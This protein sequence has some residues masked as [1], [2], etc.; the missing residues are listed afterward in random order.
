MKNLLLLKK[1]KTFA[2]WCVALLLLM[3]SLVSY[4]QAT[5]PVFRTAWGSE[6]T[7]W[8]NSGCTQRTSAFACTGSD[9][10]TFDTN[11][12]SRVLFFSGTAAQVVFQLKKSS[13][14]G[15][16][17]LTVTQS[18]DGVTYS[19]AIG[20][21]GTATGA[22][23]ITDCGNIT[24]PLLSTTRYIKWVYTK[25]TGNCDMDEVSVTAPASVITGGTTATTAFSTT[26]GTASA[27]K[28]FAVSGTL[29][30]NPL[31]AT[32]QTGFEV[33]RSDV[34][35]YGATASYTAA[36]ANAGGISFLVR[37]KNN[38]T[39]GNYNTQN[40][41][42]LSS[43]PATNANIV[44]SSS[45]N[46]VSPLGLTI[47]GLTAQDK[48][49]D[50]NNTATLTGTAV[51]N[52][53]LFS[54]DVVLGGTPS[55]TFSSAAVG[56]W[57]VTVTG[58]TISGTKAGN[59]TVSQPTVANATI[60]PSQLAD[61]VITFPA[62]GSVPYGTVSVNL[63]ATSDNPGG[64]PITYV[65]SNTA[66]ATISGNTAVIVGAGT[67]TITASQAGD[68]TH[69]PAIDQSQS[70][71]VT[72]LPITITGISA[73]DKP[74][75]GTTTA[76]LT[77]TAVL[78]PAPINSDVVNISGTP[79]AQFASANAGTQAVTVTGYTISGAQAGNYSFTQ[80]IVADATITQ[81]SQTITTFGTIPALTTLSSPITLNG[82]ASS[83]LT[84]TFESSNTSVATI[85]GTTMTIVGPG[86]VTITAKQVGNTNYSAAPELTQT[87]TVESALYLNQF[88]GTSA[89]PTQG[90]TP[91]VAAN[92]TG[93]IASRSTL[94]CASLNNFFSST[95]LNVTS[96][97]NNNSYIEF[98]ATAASGYLM[99]LTKMSFLRSGS[100]T[101]PNQL[102]VRY[103]TDGF[104]TSTSMNN[105][106]LTT[107]TATQLT[108]DFVD[109]STPIS[110][111]V[112]FRIYPYGTQRADL[113]TGAA[114]ATGTFRVDDLTIYG[115]VVIP[116]PTVVTVIP[117][118]T[119]AV[120]SAT[121]SGNVTATGG[122]NVLGNGIVYSSTDFTPTLGEPGVIQLANPAPSTGTGSYSVGT[123]TVLFANTEYYYNAYANSAQGYGYGTPSSFYTLANVP[124]QPN[125]ASNITTT[126]FDFDFDASNNPSS[127]MYAIQIN[128]QYLQ[129]N[130]TL[131]ATA[132]WQTAFN[133]MQ[134]PT[135]HLI[136][137]SGLNANTL[138]TY[139]VKARNGANVETAFG[140]SNSATTLPITTPTLEADPLSA[141]GNVCTNTSV[142]HTFA[143]LGT[144]LTN[145]VTIGPL[146]GFTFSITG[147][148]DYANDLTLTPDVNGDVLETIYVKF[149][150]TL[151]QS[152]S[153]TP[154]AIASV[155][156]TT[157]YVTVSG[158]GIN[159][160]ASATTGTASSI[161]S[162]GAS[163]S[164]SYTLGCSALTEFG[165]QYSTDSGFSSIVFVHGLPATLTGLN[166]NT[167][168][169]FRTYVSDASGDIVSAPA[170]QFTTANLDAPLA[171]A[172]TSVTNNSFVA[173]WNAVT[174]A[175]SY[176]LDVSSDPNFLGA[177]TTM[178]NWT[179]PNNPDNN[180]VDA[181]TTVNNAKTL[182]TQ[183]GVGTVGYTP[184]QSSA[185]SAA[186]A[187][188][189]NSGNG[190]KWWQIDFST[191]G[192]TNTKVS[193]AQRSSNTG[194]K[195]FKVQY[196]IGTGGTWTDVP[197]AVITVGNDWTTGSLAATSLPAACDNQS[198]VFLRWIM[199]SNTAVNNTTVASGGTS[200]IDNILVTGRAPLFLS[201]YENLTVNG[202]SQLVDGPQIT[203]NTTY[204]YRVRS[205]SPNST[206]SNSNVIS[207]TTAYQSQTFTSVAQAAGTVC[208][209]SNGTFD[210]TGLLPNKVA[211]INYTLG[212]TSSNVLTT[213]ADASGNATFQLALTTA[214]NG[215][216]LT[217]DSVE[218]ADATTTPFVPTS[219][220][221]V[222]ITD[223]ADLVTYYVD[224]DSDGYGNTAVSLQSCTGAPAGYVT[225][226]TDCNDA[227]GSV[228]QL[229]T[230]YIDADFDGYTNGTATVCSGFGAPV[231]YSET[232][233]GDDCNDNNGS[234]FQLG[235]FYVD[236]DADGY[237]NGTAT[238]CSGFGA[239]VGYSETT[240][241]D[242]CND[243][244]SS[245]YQLGMFYVDAD[246]D[247]YTVGSTV[248][249]CYGVNAPSGYSFSSN[250]E[251]CNDAD[252]TKFQLGMFYVDA[253]A[254]TYTVGAATSV[255][256]GF[257]T[258]AGYANSA[259]MLDDC[260]DNNSAIYQLVS[261]Y[262]DA[263]GDN[264]SAGV[265]TV[266]SGAS[267]PTGY[268]ATTSGADCDDNN[269]SITFGSTFYQDA[270][271]DG[272]G[273][274][275]VSTTACTAP[276]GYV[277]NNTD[278]D[279]TNISIYQLAT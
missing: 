141:F 167:T 178:V 62:L 189:W 52:G 207:V 221:Q 67:T 204:Y 70:L 5:L 169:Y 191:L 260:N 85:S 58:Y 12:D 92:V 211:K 196:R 248:E 71:T 252:A 33:S 173:N 262:I 38:A 271:G 116:P 246:G 51:L 257:N 274:A 168:Y 269:A 20:V 24:I 127:T 156:A 39:A 10:T 101:A 165:I 153:A 226:N 16:S 166:P 111:T 240:A 43:S 131:G 249:L 171:T 259:S 125:A 250:G 241:G 34:V 236:A 105:S 119:I 95:T 255:C 113:A 177:N 137:V 103:S 130:G 197:G 218:R 144:Q 188:T 64:N 154:I 266:C 48:T 23:A 254:D 158:A 109:F 93:A 63:L 17:K 132:V 110:G 264:Y 19:S 138:Y 114:A 242:D 14:S 261:Y 108:W 84:V 89:C 184:V 239:P 220:N 228:F 273:N 53:V 268:S 112:T 42:V 128:S 267:A 216:T 219:G 1:V 180:I 6:P 276:S 244:D 30:T 198:S 115:T 126:T 121:L 210:V 41:V 149:T 77:G 26:Y 68:A 50:G 21:Y 86:T 182:T 151:V 233:A 44:T 8:T 123:G 263:D 2:F 96:S 229:G 245:K 13:M 69:N 176:Q 22:T 225:N 49:F 258:P 190:T 83:G 278:C 133:W 76:T 214:D 224:A 31:V 160:P 150:P 152:Y 275:A 124:V 243:N 56:T 251:D 203:E 15:E 232:S 91:T 170:G 164:G 270:D 118:T 82:V 79:V 28:T 97:V 162:N 40:A 60:N 88:T 106:A 159:T 174:G 140:T 230:F 3:N 217:I 223:V 148:N 175:S 202:T 256:Y 208:S 81:L 32:A 46:T 192:Y 215:S 234:V 172:A 277:S 155:G 185:T 47:T 247:G 201:G 253:D 135:P 139:A 199:T 37:L 195:D 157:I 75:D 29:L 193:S 143:V 45:G 74:Y 9:A 272:F 213:T 66:V 59:Y 94:T 136:T 99:N 134:S 142:V 90:N 231:G 279:D 25:A 205:Y 11:N 161:V 194:P 4:G 7:G 183:G 80:P 107:T 55:A 104:A 87:K 72:Q 186:S 206:S 187:G 145:D 179:F 181:A 209:G 18:A 212:A 237:T 98:S 27:S 129:A 54:D 100:G 73:L 146:D 147:G 163:V 65:S 57:P 265:E 120:D 35:S 102:E 122:S 238:V 227:D 61:Q 222:T 36:E 78:S 235:T 117:P 200:G